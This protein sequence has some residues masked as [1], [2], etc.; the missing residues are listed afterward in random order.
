[1][2][3]SELDFDKYAK[4]ASA[5]GPYALDSLVIGSGILIGRSAPAVLEGY[6]NLWM[7]IGTAAVL[8]GLWG[9]VSKRRKARDQI[10]RTWI[11]A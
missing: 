1:L 8:Y 6:Q 2:D 3:A 10:K 11:L 9:L 7:L 4:L 5:S